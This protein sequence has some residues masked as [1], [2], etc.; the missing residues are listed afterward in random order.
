MS[1]EELFKFLNHLGF[2]DI[3]YNYSSSSS[4]SYPSVL[5]EFRCED[6][7]NTSWFKSLFIGTRVEKSIIIRP[8]TS[9]KLDVLFQKDDGIVFFI[10]F[11]GLRLEFKEDVF[12]L[13]F[14]VELRD[15]RLGL[16]LV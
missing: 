3:S 16:L 9:V 10:F 12:R 5:Y 7:K 2:E 4:S 11:D 15:Y 13:K 1:L 6:F 14:G 8:H